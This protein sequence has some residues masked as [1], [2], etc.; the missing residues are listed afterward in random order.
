MK[1]EVNLSLEELGVLSSS[2][3]VTLWEYDGILFFFA[4]IEEMG[5]KCTSRA[6]IT[7]HK[8]PSKLSIHIILNNK[9]TITSC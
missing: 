7:L 6:P 2:L 1:H 3:L 4:W 9:Q 5:R 8:K